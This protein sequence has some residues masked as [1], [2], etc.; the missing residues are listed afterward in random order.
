MLGFPFL[1][2]LSFIG[3][4]SQAK[5]ELYFAKDGFTQFE[6]EENCIAGFVRYEDYFPIEWEVH[7]SV[8]RRLNEEELK[9]FERLIK[10]SLIASISQIFLARG[11]NTIQFTPVLPPEISGLQ[12]AFPLI[13]IS[14]GRQL[15]KPKIV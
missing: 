9:V 2:K 4:S 12:L 8:A 3:K 14:Q 11:V 10:R 5:Y 15:P 1:L 7:P 6:A 13:D